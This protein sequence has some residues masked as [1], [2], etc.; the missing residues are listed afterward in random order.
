MSEKKYEAER[1]RLLLKPKN[2]YGSLTEQDAAAMEAYCADYRRF[3]DR[4]KTEREAVKETVAAAEAAGFR[5]LVPGAA[6]KAGDKVSGGEIFATCRET[7]VIEHRSM[8]PVRVQ[9]CLR[10]SCVHLSI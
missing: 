2:A 10:T 7:P 1:K 4:A 5:K 9:R 8:I 3:L 6:L